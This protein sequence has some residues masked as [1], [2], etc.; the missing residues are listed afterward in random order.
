MIRVE[1]KYEAVADALAEASA[2]L[3]DMTPLHED[4]AEYMVGA[5]KGRFLDGKA[6]D[7]SKWAP[8]TAATL[9]AYLARGD[10]AR[11]RPLIGPSGRLGREIAKLVSRDSVEIGSS[12]KYSAVMQDGARKGAFGRDAGNHPIPWGDIPARRWLGI[13]EENERKI[14]EIADGHLAEAF[15][16]RGTNLPQ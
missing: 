5:T 10:G 6:P 11:P 4:I 3:D 12:L 14:I 15:D 7:G 1:F 16:E 9:A 13:S 8:K 2:R